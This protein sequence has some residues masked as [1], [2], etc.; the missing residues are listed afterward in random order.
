MSNTSTYIKNIGVQ[1]ITD[2]QK[3][4]IERTTRVSKL[5][6]KYLTLTLY[7]PR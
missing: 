1:Y 3:L 6:K 7:L 4:P 2:S 5:Y